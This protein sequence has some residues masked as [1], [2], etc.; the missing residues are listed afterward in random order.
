MNRSG[1]A[2]KIKKAGW[3]VTAIVKNAINMLYHA[4]GVAPGESL[5]CNF[6]ITG[7]T[8]SVAV[9]APHKF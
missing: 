9:E 1:S 4:G 6:A 7:A 8:R 5:V 3:S 2:R